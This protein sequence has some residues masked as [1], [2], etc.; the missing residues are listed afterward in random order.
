MPWLCVVGVVG[1]W[2]NCCAWRPYMP[3]TDDAGVTAKLSQTKPWR[4]MVAML[5]MGGKGEGGER[6]GGGEKRV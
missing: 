5:R 3:W 4:N 2:P 6:G 1:C